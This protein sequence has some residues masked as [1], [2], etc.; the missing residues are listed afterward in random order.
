MTK[1]LMAFYGEPATRWGTASKNR[2]VKFH[3]VALAFAA[4]FPIGSTLNADKFDKW[5]ID[6]NLISEPTDT[7]KQSD[8][9]LAHLQ[10][11]HILRYNI[12]RAST[13]P[14]M[15]NSPASPFV[16]DTVSTGEYEVRAPQEAMYQPTLPQRVESLTKTRRKQL[17][18]LMQS[19]DWENLDAYYK[20]SANRL[21]DDIE[22]FESEIDLKARNLGKK[23]IGLQAD[24]KAAVETGK[25]LVTDGGIKG[26][27]EDGSKD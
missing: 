11:R 21:Y 22:A 13:H 18:H 8:A 6:N 20:A 9:W 1:E 23:F 17:D 25:V 19:T 26:M 7:S 14:R 3:E 16:I 10:R 4:A 15:I 24:L 5:A 12:N 2:G 27:I